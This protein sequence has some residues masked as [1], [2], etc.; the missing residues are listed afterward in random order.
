MFKARSVLVTG[1]NRGIGLEFVK[2][3]I[4]LPNPPEHV[5]ACCRS[6]ENAVELKNLVSENPSLKVIK[7]ELEDYTSIEE[8]G[9]QVEQVVGENGLNVLI[10]NAGYFGV[11]EMN[12]KLEDV[13]PESL[14]KH[15]N[16]NAIG[17]LMVTKRLLPLIRCAAQ[18]GVGDEMSASRA[19]IIN[20]T[21]K[22][23][24]IA[25]NGSARMYGYRT[26]KIALNMINKN[27][28]VE[29]KPDNILC[30][31]MHPGWMKTDMTGPN[32]LITTEE[33]VRPMLD[34]IGSRRREHNGLLFDYKGNLI[35]W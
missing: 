4:Q 23:A 19:A 8:A 21:T 5:F 6:P 1:S 25:D 22:C 15:F 26:S 20:I 33:S 28:A 3:L 7:L 14:T 2:Q 35:P 24:S 34:V 30:V 12:E 29:L 13:T 11:S 9:K 18:Q 31:L 16:I 17:P 32:A 10:N 27:L